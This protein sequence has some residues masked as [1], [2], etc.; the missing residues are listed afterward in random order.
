[1]A[2]GT[3]DVI[4]PVFSASEV[5]V[6]FSACMAGETRFGDFFGRFVLEGDDLSRIAFFNVGF[7]GT[8]TGFTA[9][10]FILPTAYFRELSVRRV[11]KRLELIFVTIAARIATYIVFGA[12]LRLVIGGF[13]RLGR[14]TRGKPPSHDHKQAAYQQRFYESGKTQMPILLWI[15]GS[16]HS[17]FRRSGIVKL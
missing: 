17:Y 10:D 16:M 15:L 9:G 1:M 5:V 14:T 6:L 8:V 13:G 3:A 4:T 11:G 12:R 2:I 7:A